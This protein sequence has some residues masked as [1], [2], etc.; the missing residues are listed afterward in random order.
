[1][2]IDKHEMWWTIGIVLVLLVIMVIA[3]GENPGAPPDTCGG[4]YGQTKKECL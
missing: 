1:M 4:S 2:L 3:N